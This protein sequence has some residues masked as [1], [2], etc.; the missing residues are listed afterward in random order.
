MFTVAPRTPLLG[1]G[2][3]LES[4]CRSCNFFRSLLRLPGLAELTFLFFPSGICLSLR[5]SVYFPFGK[6]KYKSFLGNCWCQHI[7][8]WPEDVG[9]IIKWYIIIY[10]SSE[11]IWGKN[12]KVNTKNI[13]NIFN[14]L[15]AISLLGIFLFDPGTNDQL[16]LPNK[17]EF[18]CK[19]PCKTRH[20]A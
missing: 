13:I 8:G 17:V 12:S 16:K 6:Q 3:L 5:H 15:L 19:F 18:I 1:V 11:Y 2:Q 9:N 14:G 4:W 7:W 20:S 10:I